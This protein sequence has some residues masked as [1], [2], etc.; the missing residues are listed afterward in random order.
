MK[1]RDAFLGQ[2]PLVLGPSSWTGDFTQR[3]PLP[4]PRGGPPYY[5]EWGFVPQDGGAGDSGRVGP[6]N[7]IDEAFNAAVS[8]AVAAGAQ[9]IPLDGFAQVKDSFG[10]TVGPV[11]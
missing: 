5:G 2:V 7:T 10:R 6:F 11:T 1:N 8:A 9:Q 3:S 4:A